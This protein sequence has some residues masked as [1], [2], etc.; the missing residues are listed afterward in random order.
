MGDYLHRCRDAILGSAFMPASLRGK[1][2]RL[3]GFKMAPDSC[4]WSNCSFRSKRI[5]IGSEV[6]INVGFFYDG[7]DRVVIEDNVRMG[8]FVRLITAS[9]EVGPSHQRCLVAATVKPITIETGS[10]IGAGVTILPGVTIGRGCVIAAGSVVTRSTRPDGLYA[11]APARL[12][13]NLPTDPDPAP[14]DLE[15]VAAQ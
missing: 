5:E 7:A 1:L 14:A 2:M 10:W 15:I 11:G 13:K 8:Q 6:F 4:V 9:H 3:S 12:V